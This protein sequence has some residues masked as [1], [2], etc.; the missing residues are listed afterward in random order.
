M[1]YIWIEKVACGDPKA[2]PIFVR[3]ERRIEDVRRRAFELFEL[4]GRHPGR[5]LEDWL[6]AEREIL[7]WP[8]LE[9]QESD[10]EFAFQVPFDDFDVSQ[11]TIVVTPTEIIVQATTEAEWMPEHAAKRSDPGGLEVYRRIELS[12]PI[13]SERT[14]ATFDQGTLRITAA[15]AKQRIHQASPLSE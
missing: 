6:R 12:Q 8:P 1:S 10:R 14:N 3:I 5:E 4:R 7:G 2:K 9:T 15:K 11:V 13:Q